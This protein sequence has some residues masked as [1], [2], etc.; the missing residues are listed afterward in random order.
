MKNVLFLL[1]F[2]SC[3]QISLKRSP[4][5]DGGFTSKS[6][7]DL[8]K[9]FLTPVKDH[10]RLFRS[11][12]KS[13]SKIDYWINFDRV[14][15]TISQMTTKYPNQL[16]IRTIGEYDGEPIYRIDIPGWGSGP[17][18]NIL[19]SAGVHGNESAGVATALNFIEKN[20]YNS[21]F[22]N[23]FNI[24]IIPYMNPGGLK[25]NSRRLNN[26]IDLNRSFIHN[27]EQGPTQIIQNSLMSENFSVAL[28]LHEAPLRDKFF[29][30]KSTEDDNKITT[31]ALGRINK[32]YLYTSKNYPGHMPNATDPKKNSYLLYG[33]GEASS[34]N[35]G[36]V[37]GFYYKELGVK[38]SY[39]L[40]APG[41]FDLSRKIDIY[42]EI[43]ENYLTEI[44]EQIQR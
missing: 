20:I 37:K 39:T 5:S 11:V 30:I 31:K 26:N 32:D 40:E 29:V 28:D 1:L 14:K 21:Y 13:N 34:L 8:A 19:I 3:S 23:N 38:Y 15:K 27:L 10:S 22:R 24:V 12:V 9:A 44:L 4:A 35:K 16:D 36:T 18:Q 42:T 43:I 33:P 2:V 41:K 6:C 25:S 7:T 17:K